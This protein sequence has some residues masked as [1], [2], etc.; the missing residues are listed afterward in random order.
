MSDYSDI[1][2]LRLNSLM[3]NSKLYWYIGSINAKSAIAKYNTEPL[4]ATIL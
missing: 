3:K 1:S 4:L 2:I